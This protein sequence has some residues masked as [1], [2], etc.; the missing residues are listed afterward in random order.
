MFEDHMST[1]FLRKG[2]PWHLT[3][4]TLH[5]QH[6]HA[7][8]T[9]GAQHKEIAFVNQIYLFCQNMCFLDINFKVKFFELIEFFLWDQ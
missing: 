5:D 1:S 7:H 4:F 9:D 8:K 2:E 3:A 6:A